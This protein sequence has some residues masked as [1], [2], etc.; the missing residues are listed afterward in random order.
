MGGAGKTA[1]ARRYPKTGEGIHRDD[2]TNATQ[3]NRGRKTGA[4]IVHL[5]W[6]RTNPLDLAAFL[7]LRAR[8]VVAVNSQSRFFGLFYL[9]SEFFSRRGRR[10][11]LTVRQLRRRG[12]QLCRRGRQLGWR[13]RQFFRWDRLFC[14]R[15]QQ[16]TLADRIFFANG[17]DF[18]SA[19]PVFLCQPNRIFSRRR[20]QFARPDQQF[21]RRDQIFTRRDR[22]FS[23]RD[24]I[25]TRRNGR[26]QSQTARCS[27]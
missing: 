5:N 1:L 26:R 27:D 11:G 9:Q 8:C 15:M 17:A 4:V 21:S 22:R 3:T 14:R 18:S 25:F 16:E 24:R 12:R 6:S 2:A 10:L 23:R 19:G 13:G 20:Q 7:C